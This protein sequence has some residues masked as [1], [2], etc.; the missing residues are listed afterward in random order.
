MKTNVN[1]MSPADEHDVLIIRNGT[2]RKAERCWQEEENCTNQARNHASTCAMGLA[3]S[4]TSRIGRPVPDSFCLLGFIP[5]DWQT[6]ARKSGT[7]TG[8]SSTSIPDA[9]V[10]P[11]A[12]P[13]LMPPPAS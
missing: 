10:W 11:N 13:P 6:V 7:V 9:D 1:G 2:Q 3:P 8:C 12:W 4:C 5:S